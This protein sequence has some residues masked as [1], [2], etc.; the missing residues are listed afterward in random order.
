MPR[1]RRGRFRFG[2]IN[3]SRADCSGGKLGNSRKQSEHF[4]ISIRKAQNSTYLEEVLPQILCEGSAEIHGLSKASDA[5]PHAETNP[6][7]NTDTD[8]NPAPSPGY[9]SMTSVCIFVWLSPSPKQFIFFTFRKHQIII[10][11]ISILLS[12]LALRLVS[13]TFDLKFVDRRLGT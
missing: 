13:R 4:Q 6:D 9:R 3:G 7:A 5:D 10:G 8:T 1:G 11:E 2:D 12:K